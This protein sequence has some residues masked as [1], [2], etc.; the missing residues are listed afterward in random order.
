MYHSIILLLTI[1]TIYVYIGS[2]VI[3]ITTDGSNFAGNN[4]SITCIAQVPTGQPTVSWTYANG[5]IVQN[6]SS[7]ELKLKQGVDNTILLTLLFDPLS[8]QHA[9]MYR[10]EANVVEESFNG[11]A[12]KSLPVY[13]QGT[14]YVLYGCL[15][16]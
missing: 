9:G 11:S 15:L 1:T 3:T 4:Y 16:S 7:I 12:N 2:P 8:Y 6:G 10:C 5:S 13:V 14:L